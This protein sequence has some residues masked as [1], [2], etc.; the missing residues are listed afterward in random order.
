MVWCGARKGRCA[1]ER[2]VGGQLVGDRVDAGDVQRFVDGHARQDA[3]QGARQQGLASAGRADHE[4]V[5]PTS[6]GHFQG[7]LDVFLTLDLAEVGGR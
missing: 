4:D 1:D 7:T 6:G 5:M 2:D 3:G